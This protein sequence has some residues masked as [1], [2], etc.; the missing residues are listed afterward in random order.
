[1]PYK[2][3]EASDQGFP[4]GH[5]SKTTR[6]L[7]TR[8]APQQQHATLPILGI[9]LCFVL[10]ACLFIYNSSFIGID[11]RRYFCLI[12]DA[13]ISMRYAWNLS[14]GSGLVWNPGEYVEGYTNLLMTLLMSLPTLVLDK[15][16]AV[17]AIQIFGIVL[18][19]ANAY[20]LMSIADQLASSGLEER[21]RR[22]FVILA[23]VCALS[24]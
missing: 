10:W 1:M 12:D 14:H 15:V 9:S 21:Y 24:Y 11:G 2:P 23:F 4:G 22:L 5:L 3:K 17:L 13:M 8:S 16:E 19:L 20:L 7:A 18:V 6:R